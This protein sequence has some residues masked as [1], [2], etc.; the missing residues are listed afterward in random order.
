MARKNSSQNNGCGSFLLVILVLGIIGIIRSN[1]KE[2]LVA[3]LVIILVAV[4]IYAIATSVSPKQKFM[5]SSTTTK[6]AG[7]E[8]EHFCAEW[9]MQ[10]KNY[11]NAV[12]TPPSGDFG[13]DLVAEDW[14]A[15]KWVFQCKYYQSSLGNKP[16]QEVV[17][18]KSHYGAMYAGVITNSVF[19]EKAKQLASENQVVLFERVTFYHAKPEKSEPERKAKEKGTYT[20]EEKPLYRNLWHK[21]TY[22]TEQNQGGCIMICSNC[23]TQVPEGGNFCPACGTRMTKSS[24]PPPEP[25]LYAFDGHSGRLELYASRVV[26]LREGA[27]VKLYGYSDTRLEIPLE[28][29]ATVVF[30]QGSVLTDGYIQLVL[31][32][33]RGKSTWPYKDKYSVVYSGNKNESAEFIKDKIL[34]AI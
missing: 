8:Y 10:E 2:L 20:L 19:T 3:V 12:V 23:G 4:L 17:A 11:K 29:I 22:N 32:S 33:N 1:W 5:P 30:K 16:I 31:K 9:L 25:L 26:I 15:Q 27:F 18:A 24:P 14:H 21:K 6:K 28:E 7:I 34:D 13:A